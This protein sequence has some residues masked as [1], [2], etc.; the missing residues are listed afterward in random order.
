[1]KLQDTLK[2]ANTGASM[3]RL[4]FGVYQIHGASCV[5]ACQRAL[6]AGYRHFDSAQFYRNEAEVGQAIRSSKSV[7]REDVFLTTKILSGPMG[8]STEAMY[9]NV[10]GSVDKMGGEGGYVDLFLIHWPGSKSF[11]ESSWK[12]LEKLHSEGRAKAIGVSN[13]SIGNIEEMKE[14]ATVWPPHANQLE[15][16]ALTTSFCQILSYR[17]ILTFIAATSLVSAA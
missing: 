5:Q 2:I 17:A 16:R 6:D 3:P 14:Y 4:G 15:V 8:A 1:M 9:Q 13:F 12:A 10:A 11:R 7:P